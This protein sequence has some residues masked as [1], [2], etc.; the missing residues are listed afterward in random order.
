M[1]AMTESDALQ[2]LEVFSPVTNKII[3]ISSASAAGYLE[4]CKV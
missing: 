4:D 1:L 2:L 3:V